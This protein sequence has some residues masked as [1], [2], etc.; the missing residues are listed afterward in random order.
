MQQKCC[1]TSMSH[2]THQYRLGSPLRLKSIK[3]LEG[4]NDALI[5]S[6]QTTKLTKLRVQV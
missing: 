6:K 2:A 3:R 4:G 5:I 1:I